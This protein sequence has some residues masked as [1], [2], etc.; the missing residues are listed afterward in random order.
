MEKEENKFDH[1]VKPYDSH[2]DPLI[3][4]QQISDIPDKKNE[5]S[6]INCFNRCCLSL[7]LCCCCRFDNLDFYND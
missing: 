4:L 6:S 7:I 3:S 1:S 2:L 5:S